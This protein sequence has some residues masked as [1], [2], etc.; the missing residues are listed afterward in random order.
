MVVPISWKNRDPDGAGRGIGWYAYRYGRK[1]RY[2]RKYHMKLRYAKYE[3]SRDEARHAKTR[4][5]GANPYYPH[6]G[7]GT[8]RGSGDLAKMANRKKRH[9]I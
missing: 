4:V 2:S 1:G 5:R 3:P 7:D 9:T 6:V 8:Y